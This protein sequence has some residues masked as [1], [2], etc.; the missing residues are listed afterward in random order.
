MSK[1][2]G[3]SDDK[4]KQAL[5]SLPTKKHNQ[6]GNIMNQGSSSQG[7]NQGQGERDF[8]GGELKLDPAVDFGIS[9]NNLSEQ[10]IKALNVA[11][12]IIATCQSMPRDE[13]AGFLRQYHPYGKRVNRH[14]RSIKRISRRRRA[15]HQGFLPVEFVSSTRDIAKLLDPKRYLAQNTNGSQ[16]QNTKA[17]PASQLVPE[18]SETPKA[19]SA[20]PTQT[21]STA[22]NMAPSASPR[23]APSVLP[24]AAPSTSL[25]SAPKSAVR[26]GDKSGASV[27]ATP[28]EASTPAAPS[29]SLYG[30]VG[31]YPDAKPLTPNYPDNFGWNLVNGKGNWRFPKSEDE[32][33]ANRKILES[34]SRKP[35]LYA[36]DDLHSK[37]YA[38]L[39]KYHDYHTYQSF[40]E[41]R[42]FGIDLTGYLCGS[43]RVGFCIIEG[44]TALSLHQSYSSPFYTS[45]KNKDSKQGAK[46]DRPKVSFSLCKEEE[47][48]SK[49]PSNQERV[50]HSLLESSYASSEDSS[51]DSS[52][53]VRPFS[54]IAYVEDLCAT[55]IE[56]NGIGSS[57]ESYS[58]FEADFDFDIASN[59]DSEID[60]SYV[61]APNEPL[62]YGTSPQEIIAS[63]IQEEDE[64]YSGDGPCEF[65]IKAWLDYSRDTTADQVQDEVD[66]SIFDS[67]P[68]LNAYLNRI[69]EWFRDPK[70]YSEHIYN[71]YSAKT[72]RDEFKGMVKYFASHVSS[73]DFITYTRYLANEP[74]LNP[75]HKNGVDQRENEAQLRIN[76]SLRYSK[77]IGSKR[78]A[79]MINVHDPQ[80]EIARKQELHKRKPIYSRFYSSVSHSNRV[81]EPEEYAILT[82]LEACKQTFVNNTDILV[83]EVTSH[84]P[85]HLKHE[86]HTKGDNSNKGKRKSQS[87]N[88]DQDSNPNSGNYPRLGSQDKTVPWNKRSLFPTR[89]SA[90]YD[91]REDEYEVCD[92]PQPK[93]SPIQITSHESPNSMV[94]A[95]TN[96]SANSPW[97]ATSPSATATSSSANASANG[98]AGAISCMRGELGSG[99]AEVG[100]GAAAVY[101][102]AV[103]VGA[104]AAAVD[105]GAAACVGAGASI[106]AGGSGA[107]GAASGSGAGALTQCVKASYVPRRGDILRPQKVRK[108]SPYHSYLRKFYARQRRKAQYGSSSSDIDEDSCKEED[109]RLLIE[110]EALP[111]TESIADKPFYQ[112]KEPQARP[113]LVKD[114]GANSS[115]K[116]LFSTQGGMDYNYSRFYQEEK[117][118]FT[119]ESQGANY[120]NDSNLKQKI[121][122]ADS[123]NHQ[124]HSDMS[125][126]GH[127]FEMATQLHAQNSLESNEDEDC[128]LNTESVYCDGYTFIQVAVDRPLYKVFDYKILGT[129]NEEI[130]GRR[131]KIT[132]GRP[133]GGKSKAQAKAAAAKSQETDFGLLSSLD[134]PKS[135][136]KAKSSSLKDGS[137]VGIITG[138]GRASDISAAK[139]REATFL[140]EF[141][142]LDSAVLETLDFGA[143]YYHHPIGQAINTALPKLLR[144]VSEA[145]FTEEYKIFAN[146]DVSDEE[147]VE[148]LLKSLRGQKQKELMLKVLT[149]PTRET[150]LKSHGFSSAVIKNMVKRGYLNRVDVANDLSPFDLTEVPADKIVKGTKPQLNEEQQAA[151]DRINAQDGF[152]VFLLYG[153][154]GSGK[155]EVYLQAIEHVLK[156][157]KSVLVLVPEIALT[158]QTFNRFDDRFAVPITS[159]HSGLSDVERRNNYLAMLHGKSAILIGT[160]SSMF[161][162]IPNLGLIVLDEEHDTS[163]KQGDGFRYSARNLAIYRA[164]ACNC[165]IVMGSATPSLESICR[166]EQGRFTKLELKHRAVASKLPQIKIVDVRPFEINDGLKSGVCRAL[167]ETIGVATARKHQAIIFLNRRGYARTLLCQHCAQTLNCINC[168]NV[169]TLHKNDNLLC[170]HVCNTTVRVPDVCPHCGSKDTLLEIGLGTEQVTEYLASRFPDV[171]IERIDRDVIENKTQLEEAL[172]RIRNRESLVIVG[173]Q[174]LAKGH[175]F[176]HVTIVCILDTD[177]GL[178]SEDSRALEFTAQLITQVA[179]R[180]GRADK[181]GVV[182]IQ[183]CCPE[184]KLLQELTSKNF[185]YYDLGLKLLELRKLQQLPP[186]TFQ[187]LVLTNSPSR[188][189]ARNTLELIISI[190]KKNYPILSQVSLG[191]V[192]PD[193]M[194]RRHKRY[195]YNCIITANSNALLSEALDAIVEV[196]ANCKMPG[197][198]RFA[199][200]VDPVVFM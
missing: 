20:I 118:L 47:T 69:G 158:P 32:S 72:I 3:D 84:I 41:V 67:S 130:V 186:Y 114:F 123:E 17:T 21:S 76:E 101:A 128:S 44:G 4:V 142:I 43:G 70:A 143:S 63:S 152:E 75:F 176:P 29:A 183:T 59:L 196:Q 90:P 137:V 184:H 94:S 131:V 96:H 190:A 85:D 178:Y 103:A 78:P 110:I 71:S 188:E 62:P 37:R 175:D 8:D 24:G 164:K 124:E 1:S 66:E 19:S 31:S 36:N 74:M 149:E 46:Q 153:V 172:E 162:P 185:D 139:V 97:A 117:A 40:D 92:T 28:A 12:A 136:S 45:G 141:P 121:A 23:V 106:F 56:E 155:T 104:G 174:M 170:C 48:H 95:L 80:R 77:F 49:A 125:S 2:I 150:D 107:G 9:Q 109:A 98:S 189:D 100:A 52:P 192:L 145:R 182:F 88:R 132:F 169:M 171:G 58:D 140:E 102:G 200:D 144:T 119:N 30:A 163:F 199:I 127:F 193:K 129:F 27:A 68:H 65:D 39:C 122:D 26:I 7:A 180:A 54:G 5:M 134:E 16:S 87:S 181:A 83:E 105:A 60:V 179:G 147:A 195:H 120:P 51:L 187:A 11:N 138:I 38:D 15:P 115:Q 33:V 135:K 86:A 25:C 191:R 146:V 160:R 166:A 194:E 6:Q 22:Q 42:A 126:S 156:Q 10:S 35:P 55:T 93:V 53:Y 154:T 64:Y 173:T 197:D 108:D 113:Y 151:V 168:D 112:S 99:E 198:T 13:S 61:V 165:K 82:R 161:V 148:K 57:S 34:V 18:A 50:P 167:E 159:Y 79:I 81:L 89:K 111:F 73:Y 116:Q 91:L 133:V 14:S 157:G 177:S